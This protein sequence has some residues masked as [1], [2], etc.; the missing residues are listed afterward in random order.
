MSPQ[1]LPP[2]IICGATILPGHMHQCQLTTTNNPLMAHQSESSLLPCLTKPSNTHQTLRARASRP[3]TNPT[4]PKS[5][6]HTSTPR[7]RSHSSPHKTCTNKVTT[8][9]IRPTTSPTTHTPTALPKAHCHRRRIPRPQGVPTALSPTPAT[10]PHR[11][12][13]P[14]PAARPAFGS[15]A[16]QAAVATPAVVGHR[17]RKGRTCISR[18]RSRRTGERSS[19]L[20]IDEGRELRGRWVLRE[21]WARRLMEP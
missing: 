3:T 4:K 1:H 6:P 20:G 10:A 14:T 13:A 19:T 18:G 16:A 21:T 7:P 5:R 2:C 11:L 8:A 9:T 15:V 17:R 12:E